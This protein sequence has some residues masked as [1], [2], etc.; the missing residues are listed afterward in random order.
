MESVGGL[1]VR[2][3]F[4][5]FITHSLSFTDLARARLWASR[6]GSFQRLLGHRIFINESIQILQLAV[7]TKDP[8]F[9]AN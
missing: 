1:K 5:P 7:R 2:L 9:L 6:V 4:N 3:Q 8:T